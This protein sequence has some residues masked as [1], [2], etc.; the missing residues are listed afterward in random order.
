MFYLV[1]G[2]KVVAESKARSMAEFQRN[3]PAPSAAGEFEYFEIADDILAGITGDSSW[4]IDGTTGGRDVSVTRPDLSGVTY[5]EAFLK[6]EGNARHELLMNDDPTDLSK[7]NAS[8]FKNP[9][10]RIGKQH[11]C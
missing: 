10:N 2:N 1:N 8:V 4:S 5:S 11:I 7:F 6:D 9:V 3:F